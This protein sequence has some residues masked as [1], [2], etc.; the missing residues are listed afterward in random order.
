MLYKLTLKMG[1]LHPRGRCKSNCV[2]VCLP[3]R[4][5]SGLGVVWIVGREVYAHGYSSGGKENLGQGS[6]F[7]CRHAAAGLLQIL[8]SVFIRSQK[9]KTWRVWN[10]GLIW[11]DAEHIKLWSPS[12]G[13]GWA[14]VWALPY[15]VLSLKG[16]KTSFAV[17]QSLLL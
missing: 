3:Q 8:P 16:W 4:L 15:Q 13:L 6:E 10:T 1:L 14:T 9:A 7:V 2:I 12:A 5:V 17:A 11:D